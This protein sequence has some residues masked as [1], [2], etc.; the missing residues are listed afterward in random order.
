MRHDI[1]PKKTTTTKKPTTTTKKTT[2]TTKK[3]TTTTKKPTTTTKKTTTTTKKATTT[4]KKTTT[5]TKKTTTT[6]KKPTTTTKK[7]TTTTKKPTTTTKKTTTTTKKTTTTTHKPTT[8]KTTTQ[9]TGT[10][11]FVP[12][13]MNPKPTCRSYTENFSDTVVIEADN[14]EPTST[15]VDMVNLSG[16]KSAYT[17]KDD[18]LTLNMMAPKLNSKGK[19]EAAGLAATLDFAFE[20]QYGSYEVRMKTSPVNGVCTAV[21]T[22]S[23]DGDEIDIEMAPH[24]FNTQPPSIQEFNWWYRATDTGPADLTHGGYFNLGY[25]TSAEFHTYRVEWKYDSITWIT[26][27]VVVNSV[28][29]NQT[30]DGTKYIYPTEPSRLEL[31]IWDAGFANSD[32]SGGPIPWTDYKEVN[33]WFDYVTIECDPTYNTV[34]GPRSTTSKALS[35][36]MSEPAVNQTLSNGVTIGQHASPGAIPKDTSVIIG[37]N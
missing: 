8:T 33:A 32:W 17:I 31:G 11:S 24:Y 22:M 15:S 28:F 23:A 7:T 35:L 5:T 20:M 29:K 16:S 27:G 2:T 21:N 26:D 14:W 10:G 37:K 6:T 30:W 4:T 18:M 9:P 13:T 25:N 36:S 1:P 12:P 34:I 3:T 19:A